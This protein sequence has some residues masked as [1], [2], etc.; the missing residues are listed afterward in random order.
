MRKIKLLL[1]IG[2]LCFAQLLWAQTKLI[3]G[4]ITD[5]R[6]GMPVAGATVTVKRP[7]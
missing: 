3:T 2:L 6:D 1:L 7:M 4:R 5:E